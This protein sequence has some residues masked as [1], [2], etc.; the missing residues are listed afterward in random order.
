VA[1]E[2]L[3]RILPYTA[4]AVCLAAIY[5]GATMYSRYREA[6]DEEQRIKDRDAAANRRVVDMYGGD[7]LTIL[8]FAAEPAIVTPGGKVEMCYG[9]S[10]ATRVKI[11]PD[12]P[13]IKPAVTHCLE[14]HPRRTTRYTLT[15]ED[16]HGN[17]KE[18]G[19]TIR[20]IERPTRESD[21]P[22]P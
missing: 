17:R 4:V 16:G 10:N 2:S 3:R 20:V 6:R 12:A 13:P 15:A 22:A 18:Q 8:T 1:F 21:S 7:R 9:V 19:L 11:E 5:S 14:V